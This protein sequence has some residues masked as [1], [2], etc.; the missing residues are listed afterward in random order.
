VG[1]ETGISN[2]GSKGTFSIDNCGS[3]EE[4]RKKEI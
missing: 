1:I 4:K 3:E 2:T